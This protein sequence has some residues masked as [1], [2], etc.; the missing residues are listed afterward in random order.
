MSRI[1]VF[2]STINEVH[3][4]CQALTD[5]LDSLIKEKW[6]KDVIIQ[7][8]SHKLLSSYFYE[9]ILV[10]KPNNKNKF[11]AFFKK[12]E[13]S[14]LVSKSY[15]DWKKAYAKMYSNDIYL[16]LTIQHADYVVVNVEG[17][18]HHQA[19]LGHQML[20]IG[21]M[22]TELGKDVHWVNFSVEKENKE[23]LC[24]ALKGAISI[25]AREKNSYSYLKSLGL[26]VKQSFDTAL[27]AN[28]SN[29]TVKSRFNE[30][31][32]YCLFTGSNI[33]KYD[34]VE[35]AKIIETKG[36]IPVY[37]PMGLNDFSDLD[38]IKNNNIRY[39]KLGEIK[40]E[41][42]VNL[43]KNF[44]FVISGRH[45]LN[46]FCILAEKQFIP[47]ESNTW[48]IDGVCKMLDYNPS[49][50]TELSEKIN[51]VLRNDQM[52]IKDFEARKFHLKN[53]AKLNV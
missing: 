10:D 35:I 36:L 21:K 28:Y 25:S 2:G 37:L 43:I 46:I 32:N 9:N 49:F 30:N 23:I 44:K 6:G 27:L 48:K 12:G 4:G 51:D 20:A 39:F 40:F 33:K 41:D 26:N 18:I 53:L 24:D 22:A 16:K 3:I 5:G 1:V 29:A 34:L 14:L 7:H 13:R 47:L 19:L 8:V 52:L 17:T 11:S 42:V 15:S 38:K 45:H 50:E 31:E